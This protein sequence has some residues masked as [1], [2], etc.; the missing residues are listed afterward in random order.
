VDF[1]EKLRFVLSMDLCP[2]LTK[3]LSPCPGIVHLGLVSAKDEFVGKR[4]REK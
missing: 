2:G 3:I 1:F 4:E